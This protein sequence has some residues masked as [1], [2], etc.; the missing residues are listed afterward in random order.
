LDNELGEEKL[1]RTRGTLGHNVLQIVNAVCE[2]GSG[3]RVG[4]KGINKNKT[5]W[6]RISGA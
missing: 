3:G 2:K 5:P 1:A 4:T 6:G